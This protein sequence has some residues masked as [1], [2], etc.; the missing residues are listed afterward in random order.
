MKKVLMVARTT[1]DSV[2]F[3]NNGDEITIQAS[4]STVSLIRS[5]LEERESVL[6]EVD[7]SKGR[8]VETTEDPELNNPYLEGINKE[9]Y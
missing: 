5:D 3:F 1:D 9:A 8:I 2:V 7:L 6:V 4:E